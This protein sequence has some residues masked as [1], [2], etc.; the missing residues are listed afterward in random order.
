MAPG[1]RRSL[2]RAREEAIATAPGVR[3]R[4]SR[5]LAQPRLRLPEHNRHTHPSTSP[6]W[7][8]ACAAV[9]VDSVGATG[10]AREIMVPVGRLEAMIAS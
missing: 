5:P 6:P 4:C 2:V 9:P 10:G 3:G 1:L 8:L 7:P